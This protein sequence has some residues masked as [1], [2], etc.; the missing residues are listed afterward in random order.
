MTQTI[1]SF[2]KIWIFGEDQQ[3]GEFSQ[4][5]LNPDSWCLYE[6]WRSWSDYQIQVENHR[7]DGEGEELEFDACW[8]TSEI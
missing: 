3:A 1:T 8:A 6:P 5:A 7:T 4:I 2:E